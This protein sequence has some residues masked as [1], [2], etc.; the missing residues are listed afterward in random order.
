MKHLHCKRGIGSTV[1][2]DWFCF[3]G[4]VLLFILWFF[5]FRA[6]ANASVFTSVSHSASLDALY[7]TEQFVKSPLS[8]HSSADLSSIAQLI[9]EAAADDAARLILETET[10][11]FFSERSTER[12]N[13]HVT[14]TVMPDE[15]VLS[16]FETER[17][18]QITDAQVI[19]LS[20]ARVMVP[21][22][23]PTQYVLIASEISCVGG[24]CS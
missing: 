6:T 18:F 7:I 24:V 2:I 3:V 1:L 9:N 5:L 16:T 15:K 11:K 20:T 10:S 14:I 12:K 13:W 4:I 22:T 23:D 21:L 17:S 19:P 8:E